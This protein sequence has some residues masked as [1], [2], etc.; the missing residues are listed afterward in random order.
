MNS[1]LDITGGDIRRNLVTMAV[2]ASVGFL[3]NTLYNVI[4]T[5]WGGRISTDALAAL[6]LSFPVFLILLATGM[7]ISSGASALIA[8]ALG[9]GDSERAE[10]YQAQALSLA[11][12]VSAVLIGPIL[13]SLRPIF[14]FMGA[15]PGLLDTALAYSTVLVGGSVFFILNAVLN[16]GLTARGDTKSYRNFLILGFFINIGLDPLFMNGLTIGNTSVIP[17]MGVAGIAGAT[18]LIQVLG[19]VYLTVRML[20]ARGMGETPSVAMVR[21]RL[22]YWYEIGSQGLPSALNMAT[23]ALGGF[24]ITYFVT[25]FGTSAVAA[26]GSA[27]RIE[28][29]ALIPTIGL[30]IAL[31]T[32]VGQNNGAGR[33]DRVRDSYVTSLKMGLVVMVG[34][35]TPVLIFAPRLIGLFTSDTEV[36]TIGLRYLYIQAITFY[37][38]VVMNQANSVLQGLKKP[39]MIMW[40]GLYRQAA[41][42]FPVFWALTTRTALGVDGV[43]WGL[44]I[45]NWSA[46]LF[47][48]YWARRTL[49][50]VAHAAAAPD[51]TDQPA[52]PALSTRAATPGGQSASFPCVAADGCIDTE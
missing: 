44:V 37:S 16:A 30:N 35:L 21:P 8:N 38:Y 24:V 4:D 20:R 2:P 36:I 11:V 50:R 33:L 6:S 23:I 9:A 49:A 39:A 51:R 28:Q 52:T 27:L 42:P 3:F 13:F 41:A 10:R 18:I 1:H 19:T 47:T 45:V 26:Y 46:A 43:W 22:D 25:G 5:Y 48:L 12:L 34:I 31:A 29:I 32:M 15:A 40:V 14:L 17:A 7:G